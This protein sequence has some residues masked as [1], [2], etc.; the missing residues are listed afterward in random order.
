[1]GRLKR[2]VLPRPVVGCLSRGPGPALR[3]WTL[4]QT[5]RGHIWQEQ[6]SV[7][8]RCRVKT[9]P[10][11]R[12]HGAVDPSTTSPQVGALIYEGVTV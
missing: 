4:D 10:S 9:S 1:V 7:S 2:G 12:F 8:D 11:L 6:L 3:G 5:P